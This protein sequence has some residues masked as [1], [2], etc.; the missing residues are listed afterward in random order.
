MIVLVESYNLYICFSRYKFKIVYELIFYYEP[1]GA[2]LDVCDNVVLEHLVKLYIFVNS[3]VDILINLG[4]L[5]VIEVCFKADIRGNH[6]SDYL[7]IS[8]C[9]KLLYLCLTNIRW[10]IC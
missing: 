2:V 4:W 5:V 3:L 10:R 6:A 7:Y 8:A 9:L 1:V